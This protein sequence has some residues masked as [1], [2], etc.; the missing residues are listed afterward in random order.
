[1][2]RLNDDKLYQIFDALKYHDKE[3]AH[4]KQLKSEGKDKEGLL[5]AKLRNKLNGKT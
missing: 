2:Q 4:L 1:M 5:E 3:E